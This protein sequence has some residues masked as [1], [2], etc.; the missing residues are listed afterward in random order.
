MTGDKVLAEVELG[1]VLVARLL[2][3]IGTRV[4]CTWRLRGQQVAGWLEVER[5]ER[6]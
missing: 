5:V 1:V 2:F 3:Q 6:L 4:F